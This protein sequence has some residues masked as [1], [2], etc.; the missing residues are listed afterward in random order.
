MGNKNFVVTKTRED[1]S[2]SIKLRTFIREIF[3]FS[4]VIRKIL[5]NF[6]KLV[7]VKLNIKKINY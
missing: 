5:N 2:K 3:F 6:L 1:L 7:N 4:L